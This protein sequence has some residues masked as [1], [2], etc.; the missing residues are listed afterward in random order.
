MKE[1][2]TVATIR[3]QDELISQAMAQDED[4]ACGGSFAGAW[5]MRA[6][7]EDIL[8]EVFFELTSAYRLM[9]PV[10]SR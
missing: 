7:A 2:A 5:R 6:D 9:E 10:V 3:E 1:M 4:A 8:Q